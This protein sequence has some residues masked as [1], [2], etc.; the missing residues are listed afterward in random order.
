MRRLIA[1]ASEQKITAHD[2]GV[3][4]SVLIDLP[5]FYII[6][7]HAIDPMHIFFLG[8]AKHVIN[9]W[10][11]IGILQFSHLAKLQEKV[12]LIVPPPKVGSM[13]RK[14]EIGLPRL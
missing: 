9:T 1:T 10:K 13:P 4:F 8:L 7:C 3:K 12:D 5:N 11:D 14:I 6:R 2:R